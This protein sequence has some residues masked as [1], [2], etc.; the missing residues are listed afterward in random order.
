MPPLVNL[1][2]VFGFRHLT[3]LS[4]RAGEVSKRARSERTDT[5]KKL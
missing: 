4:T 5:R 3:H 2:A 1:G